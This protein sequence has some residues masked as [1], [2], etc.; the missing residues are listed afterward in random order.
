[1]GPSSTRVILFY[2]SMV[3]AN[4]AM[5]YGC[6]RYKNYQNGAVTNQLTDDGRVENVLEFGAD[7]ESV[8]V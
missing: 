2:S 6:Y 4:A 7:S 3:K 5:E 1:V 8:A